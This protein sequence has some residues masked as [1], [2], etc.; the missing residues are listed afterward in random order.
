MGR[1]LSWRCMIDGELGLWEKW[2]EWVD[3]G[4][5]KRIFGALASIVLLH[6]TMAM[7]R[8]MDLFSDYI[9]YT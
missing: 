2:T 1:V 4:R 5:H 8:W 9:V 6:M 7:V 3:T